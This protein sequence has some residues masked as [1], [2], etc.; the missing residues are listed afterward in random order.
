MFSGCF[1]LCPFRVCPLDPFKKRGQER[2]QSLLGDSTG[3][4]GRGDVSS[5]LK[6]HPTRGG[7]LSAGNLGGGASISFSRAEIPTKAQEHSGVAPVQNTLRGH[8]LRDSA[9]VVEQG[10]LRGLDCYCWGNSVSVGE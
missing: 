4:P 1:S 7:S 5:L 10:F 3:A 8:L 9:N 6:V 2:V